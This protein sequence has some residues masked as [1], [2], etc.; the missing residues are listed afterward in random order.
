MVFLDLVSYQ[1]SAI[2]GQSSE[3]RVVTLL[4]ARGSLLVARCVRD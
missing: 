1:L 3:F 4:T 2:S